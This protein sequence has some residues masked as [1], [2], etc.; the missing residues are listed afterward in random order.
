MKKLCLYRFNNLFFIKVAT[1]IFS[2]FL[3]PNNQ[4]ELRTEITD[5]NPVIK[6]EGQP[7]GTILFVII[8]NN[9]DVR[10]TMITGAQTF[11]T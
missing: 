9:I 8:G 1:Y 7:Y 6:N 11:T 3:I 5:T 4:T 2:S 10:I